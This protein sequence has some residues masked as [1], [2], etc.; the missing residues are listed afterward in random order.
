MNPQQKELVAKHLEAHPNLDLV[1]AAAA[2]GIA[3]SDIKSEEL[4][5]FAGFPKVEPTSVMPNVTTLG[6]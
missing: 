5:E 4:L 2:L 1:T 3:S 6:N